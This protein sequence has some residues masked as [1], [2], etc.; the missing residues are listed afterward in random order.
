[1]TLSPLQLADRLVATAPDLDTRTL[2]LQLK[3]RL[4]LPMAKIL[5]KVPGDTI[6]AKADALGVTRASY[7][8]WLNGEWRPKVSEALKIAKLT[9]YKL[10]EITGYPDA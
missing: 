9:G 3:I 8:R 1:M 7:H 4:K 6:T 5:E 10:H 2:A